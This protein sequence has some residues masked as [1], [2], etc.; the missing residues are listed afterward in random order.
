MKVLYVGHYKPGTTTW[1][2]GE[3]LR[4]ILK[5][6]LFFVVDIDTPIDQTP[7][8]FRSFGW[9]YYTG[10]LITR[11]ND[12]LEAQIIDQPHFDLVW[13]DK[14]V[15]IRPSIINRFS[16][17][18]STLVHYTPDTAFTHNR[19]GLFFEALPYYDHCIT[20]KSFELG[21][22]KKGGVQNLHYCTQGYNPVLHKKYYELA[23]K[24]GIIF[25]GQYEQWREDVIRAIVDQEFTISVGGAGWEKFA[26]KMKQNPNFHYLG[27][28]I[29]HEAYARAI[30][31]SKVSLGLL[32][33]KFPEKHTT[34][35]FEIPACYTAL[36]T[37][38]NDEILS[39]YSEDEVM[40]FNNIPELLGKLSRAM[41]DPVYLEN[42]T[43]KG[44]QRVHEGGF[45]YRSILERLVKEMKLV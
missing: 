4:E 22:Y 39:F 17:A 45:D 23:E 35:T 15:F 34:R 20:T 43:E 5:P 29:F 38:R 27:E 31:K 26:G 32:A 37:E 7:R 6:E 1:A 33:R 11:I 18:G 12:Y 30:S 3:Q 25:I 8:I 10:P 24:D 36:A 42:I 2:R 16:A 28:K 40:Y 21:D 9:R 44:Y 13:I 41:S 19:S 14:G